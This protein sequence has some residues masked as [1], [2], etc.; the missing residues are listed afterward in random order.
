MIKRETQSKKYTISY[1]YL[2]TRA[3]GTSLLCTGRGAALRACD[4]DTVGLPRADPLLP[5]SPILILLLN[6]IFW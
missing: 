6:I 4:A 2:Y 5:S 1:E 3:Q